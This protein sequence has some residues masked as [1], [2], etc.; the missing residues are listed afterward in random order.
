MLPSPLGPYPHDGLL[1]N[2]SRLH[3]PHRR[4]SGV[5]LVQGHR[6]P[7]AV[8]ER[9]Q[10]PLRDRGATGT[11]TGVILVVVQRFDYLDRAPG[12]RHAGCGRNPLPPGAVCPLD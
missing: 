3:D 12:L 8:G 10:G 11:R 9:Q 7:P 2:R 4:A 1:L 6:R 5:Y